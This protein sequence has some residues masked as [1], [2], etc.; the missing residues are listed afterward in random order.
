MNGCG[1]GKE[2]EE[3]STQAEEQVGVVADG[4]RGSCSASVSRSSSASPVQEPLST[5]QQLL[6]AYIENREVQASPRSGSRE[7]SC[8]VARAGDRQG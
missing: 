3:L 2:C 7:A 5:L 8:L 1:G 6:E 4:L